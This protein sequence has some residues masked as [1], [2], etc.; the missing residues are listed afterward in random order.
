MCDHSRGPGGREAAM[1]VIAP[2]VHCDPCLEPLIRALHEATH[3]PSVP[4]RFGPEPIRTIASCCGHGRRPGR[5]TLAD[6]RE[7]LLTDR[8][9]VERI[10]GLWPGINDESTTKTLTTREDQS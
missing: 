3:L 6:G 1:V 4:T 5:I 8:E 2:G 9:T 10:A 7:I